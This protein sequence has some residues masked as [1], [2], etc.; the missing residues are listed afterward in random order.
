MEGTSGKLPMV[1]YCK[2]EGH[3]RHGKIERSVYCLPHDFSLAVLSKGKN[4]QLRR[5][6]GLGLCS[7]APHSSLLKFC[8]QS[9]AKWVSLCIDH[10][11]CSR[12]KPLR[13][14]LGHLNPF[15]SCMTAKESGWRSRWVNLCPTLLRTTCPKTTYWSISILYH[16]QLWAV[17]QVLGELLAACPLTK[18]LEHLDQVHFKSS[19]VYPRLKALH[20]SSISAM[21]SQIYHLVMAALRTLDLSCWRNSESTIPPTRN[22]SV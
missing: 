18:R 19:E 8:K 5:L 6:C 11:V 20:V 17:M 22:S 3:G 12:T 16:V 10:W 1:N 15:I 21:T 7:T 2:E 14:L 4:W 9:S 13:W